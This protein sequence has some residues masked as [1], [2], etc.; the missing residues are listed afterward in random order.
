MFEPINHQHSMFANK[1]VE[2]FTSDSP[3]RFKAN[4]ANPNYR[5]IIER[6]GWID[7]KIEYK[8]N[9]HGFRADEFEE[10]ANSILFLGC[11]FTLGTGLT[12]EHTW[13]HLVSQEFGLKNYNLGIS[14]GSNDSAFRLGNHYIPKLK[15]SVVVFAG[16]GFDRLDI[17]DDDVITLRYNWVPK[18]LDNDFY[19]DWITYREN[20]ELNWKRNYLALKYICQ[21]YSIPYVYMS[22]TDL[23]TWPLSDN[24]RDI[25]HPGVGINSRIAEKAMQ[26]IKVHIQ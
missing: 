14:G 24:G 15:P 26:D 20:G 16:T 8:F 2:W 23:V 4:L 18:Y 3:E 1:T 6:N 19:K 12:Y 22:I 10:N 17:V 5:E 11:S 9:S 25:I 7:K 13:P 21:R